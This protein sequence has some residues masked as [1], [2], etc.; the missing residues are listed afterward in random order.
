MQ[1]NI[2]YPAYVLYVK[3]GIH[4][5]FNLLY[6]TDVHYSR[7]RE[8]KQIN[9]IQADPQADVM[10]KCWFLGPYRKC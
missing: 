3:F 6:L 8:T 7:P 1:C 9:V 5:K 10:V 2:T 4:K